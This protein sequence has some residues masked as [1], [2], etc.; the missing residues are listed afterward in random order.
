[1]FAG[2]T[3]LAGLVLVFLG[4]VFAAY[5]SYDTTAQVAVV[6]KYR[7]RAWLAFFALLMAL[8]AAVSG[9]TGLLLGP[10][11]WLPAGIILLGGA[12]TLLIFIAYV[13]VS[14]IG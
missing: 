10:S 8:L 13:A 6:Q 11:L 5:D 1:L 14:D 4:S 9:L 3:A 12:G 2:G 7:R